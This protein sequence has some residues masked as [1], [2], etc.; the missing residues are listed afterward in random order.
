M[1]NSIVKQISR[2][3]KKI[4]ELHEWINKQAFIK[5]KLGHSLAFFLKSDI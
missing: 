5:V 1:I 2:K 4:H 3:G